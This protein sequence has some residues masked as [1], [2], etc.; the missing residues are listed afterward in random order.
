MKYV[1]LLLCFFMLSGCAG[2]QK[3]YKNTNYTGNI[4]ALLNRDIAYCSAVAAGRVP[5]QL[6][7]IEGDSYSY[8]HGNMTFI[9][10]FGNTIDGTYNQST[11]HYNPMATANNL[12]GIVDMIGA[13]ARRA[14]VEEMCMAQLGWYRISEQEYLDSKRPTQQ[15]PTI[16]KTQAQV[17]VEEAE[18]VRSAFKER[19]KVEHPEYANLTESERVVLFEKIKNWISK[20]PYSEAMPLME[21]FERGNMEQV[22]ALFSLYKKENAK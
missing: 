12:S 1:I 21:A 15:Q 16:Q 20:K 22:L 11:R 9:D 4:Q 6:P 8:S 3:Y 7:R 5:P 18:A 14:Q 2:S 13:G 17:S 10:D 19:L